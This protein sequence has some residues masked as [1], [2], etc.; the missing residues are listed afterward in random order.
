MRS[1]NTRLSPFSKFLLYVSNIFVFPQRRPAPARQPRCW[2]GP[3]QPRDLPRH[4]QQLLRGRDQVA[5]RGL[6]PQEAH[7]LRA[8]ELGSRHCSYLFIFI[9]F[10]S[11]LLRFKKAKIYHCYTTQP[12]YIL[13]WRIQDHHFTRKKTGQAHRSAPRRYII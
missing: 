8:Q 6:P 2:R 13:L 10:I 4:P 1:K 5:R 12:I 9:L 3:A 11:N 7:R